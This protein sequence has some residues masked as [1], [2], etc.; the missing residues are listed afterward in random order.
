MYPHSEKSFLYRLI[1][2][3]IAIFVGLTLSY[4]IFYLV[5]FIQSGFS[6][7]QCMEAMP[8]ALQDTGMLRTF[9][10]IQSFCIFILPPFILTNLYKENPKTF[11][12]L[13]RPD[14]SSALVAMASL[15]FAIPLINFLVSWNEGMHLPASMENIETWMRASEDAAAKVTEQ[16][17]AG[18]HWTDLA[19]NLLI[20]ALLAGIGEELFFRGLLQS[21]LAEVFNKN[22]TGSTKVP[23]W[24][25]HATIWII[26]FIFSAIHMQFYGFIPRLLLGAWFGYLLWWTGSIWVPILAHFMNNAL[27]TIFGYAQNRGIISSDP[28]TVGVGETAWYTILSIVLLGCCIL[29]FKKKQKESGHAS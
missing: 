5:V 6:I 4:T 26:A 9:Q 13:N 27:S 25:T 15:I 29:F 20:I 2:L 10:L 21:M 22:R 16:M 18:T 17:L 3:L 8:G 7:T 14:L 11:L 23:R 12:S 24:T 1:I 19:A 28:D